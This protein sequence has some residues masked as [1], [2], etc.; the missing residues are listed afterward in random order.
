MRP[1]V[2]TGRPQDSCRA[3]LLRALYSAMIP[4]VSQ[5]GAVPAAAPDVYQTL[6]RSVARSGVGANVFI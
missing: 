1:T 3:R 4:G 6:V 5:L 2:Y